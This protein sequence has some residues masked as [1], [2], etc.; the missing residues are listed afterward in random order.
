LILIAQRR[1]Q[2]AHLLAG[3]GRL[4]VEPPVGHVA[5][6]QKVAQGVR[7]RRPAVPEQP[8][9]LEGRAERRLPVVQQVVKNRVEV[10]FGRVPGLEQVV[11]DRDLVD[12]L[13]GRVGIGVGREQNPL[14][15]RVEGHGLTQ[16]THPVHLR[17]ALVDQEECDGFVA[18]L[19]LPHRL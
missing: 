12:G 19:K 16:E 4:H 15:L 8:D 14:G 5:A 17:H 6:R 1:D 2:L 11:V 18:Q 7:Q 13:D 3:F 9:A 10:F